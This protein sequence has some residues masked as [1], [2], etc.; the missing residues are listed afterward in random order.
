MTG[1]EFNLRN[2]YVPV[3]WGRY[4][5][6]MNVALASRWQRGICPFDGSV[7]NIEGDLTEK[8]LLATVRTALALLQEIH[9][10]TSLYVNED[11]HDHDGFIRPEQSISWTEAVA[12]TKDVERFRTTCSD[13]YLVHTLFYPSDFSFC[14]RYW[15]GGADGY[16]FDLCA[17]VEELERLAVVLQSVG[18]AANVQPSAKQYFDRRY[19]G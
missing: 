8:T 10:T 7:L 18:V 3:M 11:W 16:F 13:D 19:A 4:N 5:A 17:S 1:S 2:G 15:L 9:G 12:G 6:L 14:L